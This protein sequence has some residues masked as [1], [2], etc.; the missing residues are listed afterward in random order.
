MKMKTTKI[1]SALLLP[2][3]FAACSDDTFEGNSIQNNEGQLVKDLS[4]ITGINS[5]TDASTRSGFA[6]GEKV[7]LITS[8]LNQ[9]LI[10]TIWT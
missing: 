9:R 5:G 1:I 10:R 3:L 2:A 7:S 6:G 4:I 8:I